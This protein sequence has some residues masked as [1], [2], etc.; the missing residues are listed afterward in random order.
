MPNKINGNLLCV[1]VAGVTG[2]IV[3]C[4]TSV[5]KT[6]FNSNALG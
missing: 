6:V 3:A 1:L 5:I 2:L 4:V